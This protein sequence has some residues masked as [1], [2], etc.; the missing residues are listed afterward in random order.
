MCS[1]LLRGTFLKV[2]KSVTGPGR[3]RM[4]LGWLLTKLHYRP[5]R[6]PLITVYLMTLHSVSCDGYL[7]HHHYTRRRDVSIITVAEHK[8]AITVFPQSERTSRECLVMKYLWNTIHENANVGAF[9]L[10]VP[11]RAGPWSNISCVYSW[12]I[13]SV[14]A[15]I[16]MVS[17]ETPLKSTK[18]KQNKS[19]KRATKYTS[20]QNVHRKT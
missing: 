19:D 3:T 2:T 15:I 11:L 5:M 17:V 6:Y 16:T 13:C 14:V 7:R 12:L 1:G 9:I 4:L 20:L 10:W 8:T 18:E